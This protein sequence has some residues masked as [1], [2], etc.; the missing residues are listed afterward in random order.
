MGKN[1]VIVSNFSLNKCSYIQIG[2]MD[3]GNFYKLQNNA[4]FCEWENTDN[5]L[6]TFSGR[7]TDIHY[8]SVFPDVSDE[9]TN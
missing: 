5:F 7:N 6:K 8:V 1:S 9:T 2:T 3:V 4:L